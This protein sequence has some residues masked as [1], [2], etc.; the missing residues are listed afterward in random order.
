[1]KNK[2]LVFHDTFLYKGWGERLIIMMG[3]ALKADIAS[4]FFSLGSFDLR[5]E[6]FRGKCISVS[7][8]V[9]TKGV[10]HI[11]LKLAFMFQTSFLKEY[12]TIIFSGD[13]ISAVRNCH[14]DSKKI[15]YCHTPPR[16]LYDLH[17]LYL[18]KV[19]WYLRPIFRLLC[20][21]FR[22]L[23]EY[24]ISKI[25]IIITNS[26]NTQSRIQDFLGY[27]SHV[28]YPP[29]DTQK[30]YEAKSQWYYLSFAR[31]ADAKRVHLVVEAFHHIPDE[32]LIVIYGKNDP[33]KNM[34]SQLAQNSPNIQLL[35][36]ED[37]NEL[38]DYIA[39]CRA[40]IY[41]PIDEDFGMS[42]VESMAA[43]KPVLG[44]YDGGLKESIIHNTTGYLCKKEIRKEDIIKGVRYLSEKQCA[45]M[46]WE[47]KKQAEKFSLT[48][49]EKE[50]QNYV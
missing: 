10:R 26:K 38:Y 8:E 33:Q 37:N 3:K 19:P 31:L 6:W 39:Q 24:D 28:L 49:F 29:V 1:M 5:K 32:K 41:I 46:S 15:Y 47:C 27:S 12:K 11:K 2:I 43:G 18:Q 22:Y 30:F 35:T 21:L 14:K 25:D 16:Y 36:L 9:F 50:L 45:S 20:V 23:Y 44:V 4:W 13:S 48:N 7:S 40:T 34:I 42:P 17:H